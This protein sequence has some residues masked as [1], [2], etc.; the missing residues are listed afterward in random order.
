MCL[1]LHTHSLVRRYGEYS[2]AP[3]SFALICPA[4]ALVAGWWREKDINQA[5]TS[6]SQ[7]GGEE[8]RGEERKGRMGALGGLFAQVSQIL[9][10][11][12]LHKAAC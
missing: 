2:F 7:G 1:F 5:A 12:G 11:I 9:G 3:S 8:R 4:G 6:S 10:W